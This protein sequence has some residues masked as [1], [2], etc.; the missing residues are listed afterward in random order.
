MH[1]F[2]RKIYYTFNSNK[3]SK[4]AYYVSSYIAIYTPHILLKWLLKYELNASEKRADKDYILQRVNYYNALTTSSVFNRDAFETEAIALRHQPITG[5]KVYYL[6]SYR[7]AKAFSPSLKWV[8]LPGDNVLVP[9][10]PS[11]TKSRPIGENNTNAVL[12]KLDKVRHF[13]F[14]K[15]KK[16]FREKKDMAIFRGEIGQMQGNGLKKNRLDFMQKFF[17]HPLINAG[18]IDKHFPEWNSHKL[19]IT[20][21]LDY[22]FVMSLEG[23]DVASNLKWIMSSNSIAVMPRPTCET[24]FM[25]ATLIPNYHYIEI[26]SDYSDLEERLRYYIAHPNEAEMIIQHAHEYVAQ[27]RNKRRERLISLMVLKKYFDI[28]NTH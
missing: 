20:E 23:N 12:M 24:W 1:S 8:L 10:L 6:D 5:Q 19:T 11:I 16:S 25:E 4:L 15:D 2:L 22:K 26:K 18:V 28:T 3:N 7:Y 27:F 17:G 21:H 13:L 9:H 14:V